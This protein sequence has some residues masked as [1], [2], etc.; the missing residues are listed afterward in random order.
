MMSAIDPLWWDIDMQPAPAPFALPQSMEPDLVRLQTYWKNLIRGENSMPFTDDV[1]ISNVPELADRIILVAV[2]E[3]PERFRFE[4]VGERVTARYGG[5]LRGAFSDEVQQN[6]PLK[7]FTSQSIAT[8]FHRA[9]TYYR[10]AGVGGTAGYAR[11]L[12]PTWGEGHVL[13]LLGAAVE[14]PDEIT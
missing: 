5:P 14:V 10:S 1:N 11:L 6:G 3:N 4:E 9:P 13:L 2:F 8:V 12:L 7:E